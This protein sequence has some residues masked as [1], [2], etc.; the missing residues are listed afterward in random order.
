[1]DV[2]VA[3]KERKIEEGRARGWARK[4]YEAGRCEG[5][6]ERALAEL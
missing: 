3:E 6:V 2:K 5:L 4:R 1:M